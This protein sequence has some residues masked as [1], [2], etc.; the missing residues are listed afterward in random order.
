MALT[1]SGQEIRRVFIDS[2]PKWRVSGTNYSWVYEVPGTSLTCPKGCEFCVDSVVVGHGWY[3][4]NDSNRV[5][6][7][8]IRDSA[9]LPVQYTDYKVLLDEGAPTFSG[10]AQELTTKLSGLTSSTISVAWDPSTFKF[11]VQQSSTGT[12]GFHILS[13][14]ELKTTPF[15]DSGGTAVIIE[16]PKSANKILGIVS[17][18]DPGVGADAYGYTIN[19]TYGVA[20]LLR[21]HSLRL[22]CQALGSNTLSENGSYGTIARLPMR[23]GFGE[24]EVVRESGSVDHLWMP[25]EGTLKR[26]FF[27]VQDEFGN[28]IHLPDSC[29]IS[30]T[31]AFRVREGA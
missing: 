10:I 5:L 12:F 11:T 31:L 7:I 30:F 13:D 19:A 29:P 26:L 28:L 21:V 23:E 3:P 15:S 27:E 1:D 22:N 6:R 18:T 20:I 4:I 8:R 2:G 14:E 9:S 16:N 24:L 17:A 25:V